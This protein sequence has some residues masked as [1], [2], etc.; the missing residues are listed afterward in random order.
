M[1]PGIILGILWCLF[2]CIILAG[3]VWF[4]LYGIKTFIWGIPAKLEQGIWFL[5]ILLCIIAVITVFA[6]GGNAGTFHSPFNLF[7]QR[8]I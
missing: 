8:H 2:W 7:S 4:V 5:F 6:G 1:I 3:V